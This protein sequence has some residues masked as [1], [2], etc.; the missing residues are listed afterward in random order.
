V[1]TQNPV[2]R[3]GKPAYLAVVTRRRRTASREPNWMQDCVLGES[4]GATPDDSRDMCAMTHAIDR[5]VLT[6]TGA[7]VVRCM[8][9]IADACATS[10]I[11]D[12]TV[13]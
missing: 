2:D 11:E 6:R 7:A 1:V 13:I 10:R 4:K 5:V 3:I 8:I 9:P 12:L